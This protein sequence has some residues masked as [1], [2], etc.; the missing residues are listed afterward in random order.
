[1]PNVV[2][3]VLARPLIWL[4][5]LYRL[6]IS[7]WLGGNCRFEP[8]CSSYA[9]EALQTHGVVYGSWLA[10]RRIGRCHP[11]GGSGYDPVPGVR[12]P[13]PLEKSPDVAAEELERDRKRVL[14]HAYAFISRD[15]RAGGFD[16]I[17]DWIAQDPDPAGAWVWFFDRMLGW[18]DQRTALF[19]AQH[20]LHDLLQ[21]G[22]QLQA[23]KVMLR[24]QLVDEQFRPMPDDRP[25]AIAAAEAMSNAELA[26][27]L[28]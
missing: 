24:C 13:E 14:N 4:A 15:N 2:S 16:H 19:F 27:K 26:S 23:V 18:E 22:N 9:I 6:A 20:F 5:K 17:F 12:I 1:M 28:Q 8:T 25:A 3:R 21:E 7:P 11:W 10:A